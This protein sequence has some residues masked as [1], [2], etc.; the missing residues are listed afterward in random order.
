MAADAYLV[1]SLCSGALGDEDEKSEKAFE[2]VS[3]RY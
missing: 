3:Q 2:Q 1:E